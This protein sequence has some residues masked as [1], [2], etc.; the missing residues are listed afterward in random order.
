[1]LNIKNININDKH[2]INESRLLLRRSKDCGNIKAFRKNNCILS[3]EIRYF[4]CQHKNKKR[5]KKI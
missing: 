1:M 4:I 5:T 3:I 2:L